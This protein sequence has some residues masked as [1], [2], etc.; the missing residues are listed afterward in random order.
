MDLTKPGDRMMRCLSFPELTGNEVRVLAA[1]AFHDGPGGCFPSD[2]AIALESGVRL[3]GSVVAARMGLRRKGRLRWTHGEHVNTYEI[4]YGEAGDFGDHC[5][6]NTPTTVREIRTQTGKNRRTALT[7]AD[8]GLPSCVP[9]CPE[10]AGRARC[11]AWTFHANKEATMSDKH[12]RDMVEAITEGDARVM[13]RI[14]EDIR[15]AVTRV[16]GADYEESRLRAFTLVASTLTALVGAPV[17]V[18]WCREPGVIE[19]CHADGS[20]VTMSVDDAPQ[21]A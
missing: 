1:L 13:A 2:A 4:A 5:P 16:P 19:Q 10:I 3:R 11:A 21:V 17:V 14:Q 20:V 9:I 8:A 18:S 15:E 7:R 12:K 6:G